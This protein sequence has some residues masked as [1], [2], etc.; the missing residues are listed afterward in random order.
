MPVN[1][2]LIAETVDAVSRQS[3]QIDA[4]SGGFPVGG[5]FR[6]N[7][8]LSASEISTIYTQSDEFNI[9]AGGTGS[10]AT[11]SGT[12]SGTSAATGNTSRTTAVTAG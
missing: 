6:V 7:L 12:G 2:Q 1:N 11:S 10:T 4:P 8:V 9:T 3:L 5:T